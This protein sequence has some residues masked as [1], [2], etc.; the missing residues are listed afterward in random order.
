M[1]DW[2]L[3]RSRFDWLEELTNLYGEVVANEM[4]ATMMTKKN[5]LGESMS[6]F[7][8][9]DMETS[10]D[11][12]TSG[13]L[14]ARLFDKKEL[15][16]L[17]VDRITEYGCC[18]L[19]DQEAV[20]VWFTIPEV[21]KHLN[22]GI[23]S[24]AARVFVFSRCGEEFEEMYSPNDENPKT[25][26]DVLD[27]LKNPATFNVFMKKISDENLSLILNKYPSDFADVMRTFRVHATTTH[28]R[29]ILRLF[30]CSKVRNQTHLRRFIYKYPWM[31]QNQTLEQMEASPIKRDTW[32]RLIADIPVK[33]RHYFPVDTGDWVR[34][35]IFVKHLKGRRS[36][37]FPDFETGLRVADKE[38][39][40][41]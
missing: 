19:T 11:D 10:W 37:P 38:K 5:E 34:K 28:G 30:D 12:K 9:R 25:N 13:K 26:M 6:W 18:A 2:D 16:K 22:L 1:T 21:R 4:L 23:L 20:Y 8:E 17:I 31:M 36:K 33:H 3:L 35:G 40:P 14:V 29:R 7:R 41:A 32:G 24:P 39:E 15:K 27:R